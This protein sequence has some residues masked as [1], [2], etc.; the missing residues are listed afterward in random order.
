MSTNGAPPEWCAERWSSDIT[1]PEAIVSGDTVVDRYYRPEVEEGPDFLGKL[2]PK[3]H[4]SVVWRVLGFMD[5]AGRARA[6]VA[7][8]GL[9]RMV[10][11]THKVRDGWV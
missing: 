4:Q 6:R 3:E 1:K 9:H 7:D 10:S 5:H 8:P 2:H 11:G